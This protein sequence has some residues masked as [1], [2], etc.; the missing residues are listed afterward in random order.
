MLKDT[1][2][3]VE[4]RNMVNHIIKYYTN[5]QNHH[6]KHNYK[7]NSN[8]IVYVIELTSVVMKFLIKIDGGRN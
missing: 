2:A 5:F 6:V 3:S 1:V 8:E 4:L 7:V